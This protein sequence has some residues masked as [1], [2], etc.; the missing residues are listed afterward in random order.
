MA[1]AAILRLPSTII[2]H[3]LCYSAAA[4]HALKFADVR[5]LA[6]TCAW[7][8]RATGGAAYCRR[9]FADHVWSPLMRRTAS[10]FAASIPL[11]L[12]ARRYCMLKT[13]SFTMRCMRVTPSDGSGVKCKLQLLCYDVGGAGGMSRSRFHNEVCVAAPS[14][15]PHSVHRQGTGAYEFQALIDAVDDRICDDI[16]RWARVALQVYSVG[17]S[18]ALRADALRRTLARLQKCSPATIDETNAI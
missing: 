17:V 12:A 5:A 1:A 15:M 7:M 11:D 13:R 9:W 2:T 16:R 10:L 18:P 3:H 14:W 6:R 8:N 4:D